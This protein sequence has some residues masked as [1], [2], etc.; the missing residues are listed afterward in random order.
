MIE[1]FEYDKRTGRYVYRV[2]ENLTPYMLKAKIIRESQ[3]NKK[4]KDG[5]SRQIAVL[6]HSVK[7]QLP[8]ECWH[9][10]KELY[11]WLKRYYPELLTIDKL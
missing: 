10:K 7:V 9:S 2:R 6:P 11:K 5:L 8:L 4:I 1:D 3:R